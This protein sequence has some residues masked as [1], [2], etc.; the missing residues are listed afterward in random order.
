MS[1]RSIVF[2]SL[3]LLTAASCTQLNPASQDGGAGGAS[4]PDSSTDRDGVS[5]SG[6]MRGAGGAGMG[7]AGVGGAGTGGAGMGGAGGSS[8]AGCALIMHMDEASWNGSSGE[9]IDSCGHN[10]GTAVRAVSPADTL[11]NTTG[12]TAGGRYKGAGVFVDSGGCVEVS[13][14]PSLHATTQ[15]T[16]A[17]WI[18]P[19]GFNPASNG[20]V[21]KRADY[22]S[23]SSYT[24]FVWNDLDV[25]YHL[26]ADIGN[27]RFHGSQTFMANSW[28]HVALVFDGTLSASQRVRLYVSGSLDGEFSEATISLPV[29]Q[30]PMHVGCMPAGTPPSAGQEFIGKLDDVAIWTRALGAAE[31]MRLAQSTTPL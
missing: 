26:Y 18:F 29:F 6:G 25:N 5:G 31:I 11:P 27:G 10:N 8:S 24:L 30:T 9:V 15:W 19:T 22:L 23:N 16:V 17:A 28:Y 21:G 20:I 3:C 7:G 14:D 12:G 4:L 2:T 13:D 1:Y